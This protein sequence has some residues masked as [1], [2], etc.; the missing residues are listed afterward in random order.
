MS[1]DQSREEATP[2][3]QLSALQAAQLTNLTFLTRIAIVRRPRS[4]ALMPLP[5]LRRSA[6]LDI[7]APAPPTGLRHKVQIQQAAPCYERSTNQCS[8]FACT[9]TKLRPKESP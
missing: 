7:R 6:Y 3:L 8:V 5:R 2:P 1:A 4:R 9:L